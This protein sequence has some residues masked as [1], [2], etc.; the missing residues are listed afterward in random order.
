MGKGWRLMAAWFQVNCPH[1]TAAL[2]VRLGVG[3]ATVEC[4]RCEKDFVV[5]V[6]PAH[7]PSADAAARKRPQRK[8]LQAD[9]SPRPTLT[10]YKIF[11]KS[12]MAMVRKQ[13]PNCSPHGHFRVA[14][15][16]WHDSPMNPK[17]M[18][19]G[20]PARTDASSDACSDDVPV[21]GDGARA[22]ARAAREEGGAGNGEESDDDE[23]H[24]SFLRGPVRGPVRRGRPPA[25]NAAVL[26]EAQLRLQRGVKRACPSSVRRPGRVI[27]Q[28]DPQA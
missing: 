19:T 2:Q 10:A 18:V 24:T 12:E 21:G 17:N 13:L 16:R 3:N 20:A 7:L 25:P 4:A 15:T 5:Q 23:D 26:Q 22:D 27:L 28:T 9:S 1:C 6:Q 8:A 11:M 14:S